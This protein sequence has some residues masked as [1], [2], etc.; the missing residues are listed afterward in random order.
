VAAPAASVAPY[1]CA[2]DAM[3]VLAG[4]DHLDRCQASISS[5]IA[6]RLV[7]ERFAA[8][9]GEHWHA[10][11]HR[12]GTISRRRPGR[13]SMSRLSSRSSTPCARDDV[14]CNGE[15]RRPG[16]PA[17]SP[18]RSLPRGCAS[19][20]PSCKFPSGLPPNVQPIN[21]IVINSVTGE[22]L[23]APSDFRA[24]GAVAGD[25][26]RCH[27]RPARPSLRPRTRPRQ[28]VAWPPDGDGHHPQPRSSSDGSTVVRGTYDLLGKSATL[29]RGTI[30][31]VGGLAHRSGCRYRGP[32]ELGRHRRHRPCH[33]HREPAQDRALRRSRTCRRTRSCRVSCLAAASA[34]SVPPKDSSSPAR[35]PR[36]RWAA[37][38]A[39]SIGCAEGSASIG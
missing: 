16:S 22:T 4:R 23:S 27:G 17:A 29:S 35:P 21:V 8:S 10:C 31:F 9:D 19:M 26:A 5:A 3:R 28:R 12:L 6:N 13:H 25:D 24:A 11:A 18:R 15:R 39:F 14:Q 20:M 2:T 36:W 38:R 34:R 1:L 32:V 30:T 7:L 37:G 33:R